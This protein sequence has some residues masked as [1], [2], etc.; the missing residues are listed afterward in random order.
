MPENKTVHTES[1]ARFV[2]SHDSWFSWKLL[3]ENGEETY[4][5]YSKAV[6]AMNP[7]IEWTHASTS[8]HHGDWAS[9]GRGANGWYFKDGCYGSCSVCDWLTGLCNEEEVRE[10]LRRM[11]EVEHIGDTRDEAVAYIRE[12]ADGKWSEAETM[13]NELADSLER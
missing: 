8:G 5:S 13:F 3:D 10:F 6:E 1:P 7:D 11:G 2:T 12:K 9:V 4:P